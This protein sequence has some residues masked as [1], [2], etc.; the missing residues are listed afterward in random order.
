LINDINKTMEKDRI[1]YIEATA[2]NS[3]KRDYFVSIRLGMTKLVKIFIS[4]KEIFNI[5]NNLGFVGGKEIMQV[6][7]LGS[8]NSFIYLT[9]ISI[10][11]T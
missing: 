3:K 9:P 7:L 2:I 10:K 1:S 4:L 6:I 5:K 11:V 8:N